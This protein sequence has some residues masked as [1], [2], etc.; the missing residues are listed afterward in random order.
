MNKFH[1]HN[2]TI[3]NNIEK[4][5]MK[6]SSDENNLFINFIDYNMIL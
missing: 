1:Y 2:I 3:L 6:Y 5:V 4:I